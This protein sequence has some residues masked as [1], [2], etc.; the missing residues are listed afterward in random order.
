VA[1][2]AKAIESGDQRRSDEGTVEVV[3]ESKHPARDGDATSDDPGDYTPGSGDEHVERPVDRWRRN[4][5]T[6]AV[7]AALALGFRH[8]FEPE[9][10][11][12]VGVEQ[13]APDRPVDTDGVEVH[14]DPL[15]SQGTTVVV[16][17]PAPD[18]K[19][20]DGDGDG[21]RDASGEPH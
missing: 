17:R 11:D 4:T 5:A 7:T 10:P 14:F 21:D 19:T 18:D 1:H 9:R 3:E 6:G 2:D 16:H 12:T 13:I 15:S 20:G 8:V